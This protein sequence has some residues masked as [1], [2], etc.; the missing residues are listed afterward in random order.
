MECTG[1]SLIAA[2]AIIGVTLLV[3][4]EIT[5]G[6]TI[7]TLTDVQD[8]FYNMRNRAV[9]RVQTAIN[10][11]NVGVEENGSD[12]DINITVRNTGSTTLDTP[13]FNILINGTEKV[14]TCSKSFLYPEDEAYFN[15]S[16]L[17]DT[18]F[19]T[20]KVITDNGISDYYEFNIT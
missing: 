6:A 2:T 1:F 17:H 20:L 19:Y 10:I 12:Y 13:D 8:S 3:I 14:A 7:P 5:L 9:N 15:V 11:T 18:G 16:N 4:I